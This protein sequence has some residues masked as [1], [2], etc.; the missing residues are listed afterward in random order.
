MTARFFN[1]R[2]SSMPGWAGPN[3]PR[4]FCRP[5]KTKPST[6]AGGRLSEI[7]EELKE[8]I[9]MASEVD[10][11]KWKRP[12][13]IPGKKSFSEIPAG[14]IDKVI[15]IGASTGGTV[16]LRQ[17]INEFPTDMPGTVIVQ[18]M[19]PM[20][21]KLFADKLNDT[22]R[23]EV[24][25]AEMNDRVL[26]GRVLI[27]S[28]GNHLEVIRSGG[29]Y[30][31]KCRDGEK[32]N[33]HCPSVE[34]LFNSVAGSIGSNALGVML[35]GMGRDG[36]DAMLNMRKAGARTFAQDKESSVVFGMPNEAYKC[37]GAERLVRLDNMTSVLIKTLEEM[38]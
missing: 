31:V 24:K 10:V 26:T 17:I 18:H 28:G 7:I 27:A 29:N 37:G 12:S 2:P 14:M 3:R 13:P 23:V 25:E 11:S 32:V 9:K 36:A 34:V 4:N 22:A 8:K 15:A 35:T 20:F 30:L 33:G 38:K 19:P 5:I 16:A 21:T 6:R 1:P